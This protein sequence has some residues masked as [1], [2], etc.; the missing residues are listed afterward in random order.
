MKRV[1]TIPNK[2]LAIFRDDL[3]YIFR[4]DLQSIFF[5]DVIV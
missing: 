4:D 2:V 3:Q 1:E 5:Y